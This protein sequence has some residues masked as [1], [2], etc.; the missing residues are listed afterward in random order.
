MSFWS[1][2]KNAVKAVVRVVKAVVRAVVKVV[3]TIVSLVVGGLASIFFFWVQ[4]KLRIH[5]CILHPEG[6]KEL[7]SVQDAEASVE[8]AKQLLKDRFN[9]QVLGY[10]RP[11]VQIVK[12]A[13]PDEALDPDCSFTGYFESEFGVAS[14]F[15]SR[16]T[17]GWVGI[18]ITFVFPVTVFV[19]RNVTHGSEQW[20]G[21]SFGFLTDYLVITPDGIRD[22]TTLSHELGHT[23]FLLHRRTK[24][25][26]MYH[27]FPRG[28]SITGWQKWWFRSSRHVNFW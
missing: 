8:R 10:G 6:Q 28:T 7:V 18:P 27:D 20:R 23:G 12:E 13:A 2:I 24:G 22:P 5:V 11:S 21:C 15:Y 17:A 1:K 26:L 19:V 3:V 16:W 25:N 9:V 4:K 14:D